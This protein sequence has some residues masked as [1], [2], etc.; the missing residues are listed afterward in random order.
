MWERPTSGS[1][2]WLPA[3]RGTP[4]SGTL[5]ERRCSSPVATGEARG[6]HPVADLDH[7]G[8]GRLRCPHLT[9]PT[10]VGE[11]HHDCVLRLPHSSRTRS[12]A[13]LAVIGSPG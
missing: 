9:S 3:T 7:V 11:E 10:A 2:M 8:G 12:F 4:T 1:R 6:G 13:I 5:P